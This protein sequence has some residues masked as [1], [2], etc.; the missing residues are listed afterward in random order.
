MKKQARSEML[1]KYQSLP[2]LSAP[3]MNPELELPPDL[4]TKDNYLAFRQ[5]L[6]SGILASLGH[7]AE[8]IIKQKDKVNWKEQFEMVIEAGIMAADVMHSQNKS[9]AGSIMQGASKETKLHLQGTKPDEYLFGSKLVEKTK[10]NKNYGKLFS[11]N[12]KTTFKGQSY[13]T[14]PLNSYSLQGNRPVP[15]LT[16]PTYQQSGYNQTVPQPR[17]G[18]TRGGT[19]SNPRHPTA[20]HQKPYLKFRK[21]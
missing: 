20:E 11:F 15:L 7:I 21:N 14:R 8:N 10:E 12:R 2:G 1:E 13:S 3:K 19:R 16:G 5:R 9:R 6:L 4:K 17:T 18:R